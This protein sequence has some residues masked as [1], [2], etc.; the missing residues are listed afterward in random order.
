MKFMWNVYS[1]VRWTASGES[2]TLQKTMLCICSEILGKILFKTYLRVTLPFSIL[3]INLPLRKKTKRLV[4]AHSSAPHD[5]SLSHFL[6]HFNST[7][8]CGWTVVDPSS[9]PNGRHDVWRWRDVTDG[10]VGE[11]VRTRG[12]FSSAKRHAC[13]LALPISLVCAGLY[14]FSRSGRFEYCVVL[15]D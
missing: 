6:D 8:H 13:H 5:L 15:Q 4:G 10:T 12:Q 9:R 14:H 11:I 1:W 2:W 3:Q 7:H